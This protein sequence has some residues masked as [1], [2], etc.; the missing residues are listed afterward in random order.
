MKIIKPYWIITIMLICSFPA[1]SQK[2][3]LQE[4]IYFETAKYDLSK[5][6]INLL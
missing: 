2:N 3:T 5:E 4:S 1:F 6:S